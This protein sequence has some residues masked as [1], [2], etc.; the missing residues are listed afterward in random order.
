[1]GV[2]GTRGASN[3]P[4]NTTP[5]CRSWDGTLQ[6][7]RVPNSELLGVRASGC[8]GVYQT[9]PS[10]AG[11]NLYTTTGDD[12]VVVLFEPRLSVRPFGKL[13]YLGDP[14]ERSR[15]EQHLLSDRHQGWPRQQRKVGLRHKDPSCGAFDRITESAGL[16]KA[17]NFARQN[18][19]ECLG[20]SF[21]PKR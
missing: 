14:T 1:M 3:A 21:S 17:K 12:W 8:I 15:Y 20:A 7:Q 16:Q 2:I 19:R 6:P 13:A 5:L 11:D 9:V 4:N 10:I 18:L